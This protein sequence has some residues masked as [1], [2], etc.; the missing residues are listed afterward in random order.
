M[1]T[2]SPV[3][4]S[5]AVIKRFAIVTATAFSSSK[6][7]TV[8]S[9]RYALPMRNQM[10]DVSFETFSR[11]TCSSGPRSQKAHGVLCAG[12]NSS[13]NLSRALLICAKASGVLSRIDF[14]QA[15]S[16]SLFRRSKGDLTPEQPG[17]EGSV[18]ILTTRD[19]NVRAFMRRKWKSVCW[20]RSKGLSGS[21]TELRRTS[22]NLVITPCCQ[23]M[24]PDC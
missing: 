10:T 12:V 19:N 4:N 1:L 16:L 23:Q 2:A 17:S 20:G 8:H 7:R 13:Q 15:E 14:E 9:C 6:D 21:R 11:P 24:R 18:R 3:Y 5:I 22:S